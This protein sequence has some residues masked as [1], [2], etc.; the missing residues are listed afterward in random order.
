MPAT[1]YS[2][3]DICTDAAIE[4]GLIAPG[5]NMDGGNVD[6]QWV[7][8]KLNYLVDVWQALKFYVFGYQ[9]NVYTLTPGLSPHLI[10]PDTSTPPPSATFGTGEQPRPVKIVGAATL[11]NPAG[12]LVDAPIIN[13]RDAEWWKNN[14]TK[15]IQT[16]VPTDLY[17]NADNP[18]GQLYFWP[19][20]NA[21]T[22]VR[23]QFWQALSQFDSITDP[24]GGPGGPGTLP[25][26]YRAA[27]MLT[28]AESLLPGAEK[29]AHPVLVAAALAARAAVFGNN[30]GSPRMGTRD[31]GMPDAGSKPGRR[32][33]FNWLSGQTGGGPPQ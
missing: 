16:N 13:I 31:Y 33:D 29:E 3:L 1:Q 5:E 17:Y 30:A 15:E 25:Q 10:G 12:T 28:L 26:A 7:F 19:V 8:R 20:P 22:Q 2:A 27:L 6:P 4:S 18:L 11:L 23:L 14:Q 24:I 21:A 9:F 32:G